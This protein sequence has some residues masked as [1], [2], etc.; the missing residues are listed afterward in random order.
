MKAIQAWTSPS[1]ND[2]PQ[3]SVTLWNESH[4]GVHVSIKLSLKMTTQDVWNIRDVKAIQAWTF[5][6]WSLSLRRTNP[7][8]LK[9]SRRECHTGV[10]VSIKLSLKRTIHNV[11]NLRDEIAIQAWTY[12][13]SCLWI[14]QH[15]RYRYLW[16]VKNHCQFGLHRAKEVTP[17]SLSV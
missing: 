7:A 17:S 4:T 15:R 13:P 3:L 1:N 10:N 5:P 14:E 12:P 6:S 2:I 16:D 9:P 8:D 11:R